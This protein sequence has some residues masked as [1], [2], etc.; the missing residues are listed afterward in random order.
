M[1]RAGFR[2]GQQPGCWI[3]GDGIVIDLHVPASLGGTGRRGARLGPH[4]N[5]AAGEARG[6]EAASGERAP[7]TIRALE[8]ADQ[9][10][11]TVDVAGPAAL[12]GSDLRGAAE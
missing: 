3:S 12:A 6:L 9:R 1:E 11:L 7:Q 2:R 10:V 5:V 4:G 8:A